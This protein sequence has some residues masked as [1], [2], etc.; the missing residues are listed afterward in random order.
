MVGQRDSTN[1]SQSQEFM[2]RNYDEGRLRKNL[3]NVRLGQSSHG[4][5]YQVYKD[6]PTETPPKGSLGRGTIDVQVMQV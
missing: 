1:E 5:L 6:P 3:T 2:Y 4:L